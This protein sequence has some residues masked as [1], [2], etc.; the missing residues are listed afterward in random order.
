[1]SPA[2]FLADLE[3]AARGA[4]SAEAKFRSEIAQR[5]AALEQERAF[6]FRRLNLMRSV[7][8]AVAEAADTD[9]AAGHARAVLRQ[10][11]G[12][13]SDSEAREPVLARF[14][15]V[16]RALFASLDADETQVPVA[17]ALAT[18]EAWYAENYTTPFWVLFEHY[19]PETPLVDF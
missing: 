3:A 12:W 2:A 5:I 10:K 1:M 8:D 16:G 15:E 9:N 17:A 6:A 7:A 19:I 11:L 14:A 18:F 4:E 13:H